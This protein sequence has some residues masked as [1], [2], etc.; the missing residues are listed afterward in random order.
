MA[1][2]NPVGL[3]TSEASIFVGDPARGRIIQVS[4]SGA[5]ER[6]L[7]TDDPS[8]LGNLRDLA[9]SPD[10]TALFVLSGQTI[11]HFFLPG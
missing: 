10:G 2:R 1:P 11:Y 7:S 5:F 4:R 6:A 3:A 8:V 9:L